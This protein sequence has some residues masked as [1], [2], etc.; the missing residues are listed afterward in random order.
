MKKL[1]ISTLCTVFVAMSASAQAPTEVNE[2]WCGT[3]ER[4]NARW[5]DP[6]YFDVLTNDALI[7]EQEAAN[8]PFVP[9][10]TIYK[11]PTVFHILHNGGTENI[12][13]EQIFNAIE[14]M[15]RDFRKQN[16]DTIEVPAVFDTIM[17]DAEIEF[18]LATKA[19]DGTCFKGYTRT[20]SPLTHEG[21]DGD[22]QVDAIRFG[23]DVYQGNWPSNQY[24]NVFVIADAGGAGGYTNYPSNWDFGDMS[25]GIWILHTQFGEIGTSGLSGGRSMT[26]EVGHWLNL[27]HTWGS[28]NNPGSGTCDIDIGWGGQDN[29]DDGVADTP[30]CLG[31]SSCS[32]VHNSCS[33]DDIDG[34]WTIDVPDNV[35]NYM[36]YALSCQTMFTLGQVDRMRTAITSS[37][38]GR[39]NLWTPGNLTATGADGDVYLCETRFSAD[40]TSIC[41]GETV[42]FNDESFN[43]VTGWEWSFPGGSPAVSTDQHP[44][45]VYAAPGI[46]EVSLT[47]TDGSNDQ[48][49][50]KTAYIRVVPSP[51]DLPIV[52]GFESY[53]TFAGIEEWE[54]DN[55]NG[56]GF[57]LESSV[58]L[59]SAKSARLLNHGQMSGSIDQLIASPVDLSN[60]ASTLTFSYRYAYKRRNTSDGDVLRLKVSNDCG[61]TWTIRNT[62]LLYIVTPDVQSSPFTPVS[63]D[64]W[65]TIHVTTINSTY[66]VDNFRYKFEFESGGGNNIYLDNINIYEG[67]PSDDLVVGLSDVENDAIAGLNI[68]PNPTDNELNVVFSMETPRDVV[69]KIQDLTGKVTQSSLVKAAPGRN[70][71]FMETSQLASGV[72]F[73]EIL[74]DG[75]KETRQFIVK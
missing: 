54:V 5:N 58:G 12:S 73:L 68:Y 62:R 72:Y 53:T 48:T 74:V 70:Q 47:A 52:E 65:T 14:V 26:H 37:V 34:Y 13:E 50:T 23:N 31:T 1:I 6:Q 16:A 33:N 46:Y 42:Q 59:N 49:E 67:A 75:V 27:P 19:P 63:E 7:R 32:V 10:G 57:E 36:D 43:S 39:N 56:N 24:L 2:N 35:Q 30:R 44:S 28:N 20:Q 60:V 51:T 55:L 41:A 45:V 69:L 9:K 4:M 8:P 21:D 22:A 17:G 38:G 66:F 18:V 25:N 71:V 15:T 64:D 40:R 11:I 3:S 61:E 29:N